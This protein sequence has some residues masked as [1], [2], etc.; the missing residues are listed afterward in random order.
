M[1]V[2][3]FSASK[4]GLLFFDMLN[5]YYLGA[6]EETQ[7]RMK[8]VVDNAVRLMEAAR[9]ASMPVFYAMAN[10]RPDGKSRN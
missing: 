8:P 3:E 9:K 1:N 5:V 2:N 10:H 6:S 7:K 4:T